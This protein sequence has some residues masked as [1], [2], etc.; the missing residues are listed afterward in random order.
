MGVNGQL[1]ALYNY[2]SLLFDGVKMS[3]ILNMAKRI[4]NEFTHLTV[5][6]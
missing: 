5:L 4:N 2:Y 6:I 1:L 3:Y